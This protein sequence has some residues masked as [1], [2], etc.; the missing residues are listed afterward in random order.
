MI[1]KQIFILATLAI[2]LFA[3]TP[4]VSANTRNATLFNPID[5]AVLNGEQI[6]IVEVNG[7][8]YNISLS[9]DNSYTNVSNVSFLA[10]LDNGATYPIN[11]GSN[12]SNL[13]NGTTSNWTMTVPTQN[14][15]FDN[16][17]YTV[18]AIVQNGSASDAGGVSL[19]TLFEVTVSGVRA[20]N[21]VPTIVFVNAA[22]SRVENNDVVSVTVA[23]TS[24][25]ELFFGFNSAINMS[26]DGV[27]CTYTVTRT[28]P[29]DGV[30]STFAIA[31]DNRNSTQAGPQEFFINAI[32]N[33]QG[34]GGSDVRSA[35]VQ[36][37][38]QD[39]LADLKGDR[40]MVIIIIIAAA[41]VVVMSK[42]KKKGR[43][44]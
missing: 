34:G 23:N 38:V 11:L 27:T 5:N 25:V 2:L 6:L 13:N 40:L 8:F 21:T 43:R 37:R 10:S 12:L 33:I 41:A 22:G 24:Q 36:R 20:D 18:K 26:C 39:Q 9:G 4:F 7:T 17:T 16:N 28:N 44:R 32:G 42:N 3:L 31:S 30:Y 1:K 15:L 35:V 14:F 29:A 19:N